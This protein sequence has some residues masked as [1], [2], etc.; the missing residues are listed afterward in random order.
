MKLARM[1]FESSSV[2]TA[3]AVGKSFT[4]HVMKTVNSHGIV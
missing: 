4:F 1:W 3:N 2:G